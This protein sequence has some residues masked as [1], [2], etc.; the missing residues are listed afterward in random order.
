MLFEQT[1]IAACMKNSL[2]ACDQVDYNT[3][4]A[5]QT[6]LDVEGSG[7]GSHRPEKQNIKV[8]DEDVRSESSHDSDEVQAGVKRIEAI[9][10]TWTT[11]SLIF[12]YI[13]CVQISTAELG[14]I[15]EKGPISA[16]DQAKDLTS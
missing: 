3:M 14:W 4:S 15:K 11:I 6:P 9:S 1:F 12:A 13:G 8:P 2:A 10:T 5:S 7:P 16:S